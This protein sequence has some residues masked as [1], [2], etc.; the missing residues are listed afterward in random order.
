LDSLYHAAAVVGLNT[1]AMIEAGILGKAVYTI[2]TSTFAGGQ[3]QT[4]HFHYLLARN[5]GLVEIAD[6]FPE[7][8]RQ[9]TEA[10]ADPEGGRARS[11]SFIEAF[12]RPC[13]LERPVAPI[14]VDEIERAAAQRKQRRQQRLWR[15]VAGRALLAVLTQ[16]A[17]RTAAS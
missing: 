10:L 7:H 15:R 4:L 13:G 17:R 8:L 5:G 2:R 1:S 14:V 11:R 6:G 12:V 3:E 9:L 16:R